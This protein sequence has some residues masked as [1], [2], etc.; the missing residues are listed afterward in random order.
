MKAKSCRIVGTRFRKGG[1]KDRKK[2]SND[3]KKCNSKGRKGEKIFKNAAMNARKIVRNAR[4]LDRKTVKGAKMLGR[5]DDRTVEKTPRDEAVPSSVNDKVMSGVVKAEDNRA[6]TGNEGVKA[7]GN[8]VWIGNGVVK[9]E[10]NRAWTGNEGVKAEGNRVWIGN[11]VVVN[12]V[13]KAGAAEAEEEAAD[14]P[15]TRRVA[16]ILFLGFPAPKGYSEQ[17]LYLASKE[18][19]RP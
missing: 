7:E 19:S 17:S 12:V 9:A 16:V 18:S 10:D 14:N 8:R 6:W 3:V 15:P 11:G 13:G 1:S 4:M 5:K 2:I